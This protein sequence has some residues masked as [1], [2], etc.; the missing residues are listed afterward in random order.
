MLR[1]VVKVLQAKPLKP[2]KPAKDERRV[3]CSFALLA[4][5]STRQEEADMPVCATEAA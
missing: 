1:L 3:G 4:P 2:I 5:K